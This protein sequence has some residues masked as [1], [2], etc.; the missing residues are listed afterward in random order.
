M[1]DPVKGRFRRPAPGGALP[2]VC[3]LE[4][5]EVGHRLPEGGWSD[6]TWKRCPGVVVFTTA[7][8]RNFCNDCVRWAESDGRALPSGALRRADQPPDTT[9][10]ATCPQAFYDRARAAAAEQGIP[11]AQFFRAA[12]AEAVHRHEQHKESR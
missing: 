12:V 2:D 11:L 5:W 10:W 8:G 7:A 4:L 3:C 1:V 9:I 6:S